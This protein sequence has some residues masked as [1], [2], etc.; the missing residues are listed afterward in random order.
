MN[1]KQFGKIPKINVYGETRR[2]MKMSAVLILKNHPLFFLLNRS[3]FL[4]SLLTTLQW[5]RTYLASLDKNSSFC[6]EVC[7]KSY[8]L[9]KNNDTTKS[10]S[11]N[12]INRNVFFS[13]LLSEGK[14]ANLSI[15]IKT[16]TTKQI[17]HK[18]KS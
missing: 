6:Y 12:S 3:S 5:I 10:R 1:K 16:M 2:T 14:Y 18:Y 13:L 8:I 4:H 11:K 15:T 7:Q 17:C 9:H